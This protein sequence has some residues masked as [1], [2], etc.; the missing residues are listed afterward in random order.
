VLGYVGATIVEAACRRVPVDR[1]SISPEGTVTDPQF[2][3]DIAQVWDVLPEHLGSALT[4]SWHVIMP[5][6]QA[7]SY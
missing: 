4:A 1:P 7:R 3:A 2:K 6:E 5:P